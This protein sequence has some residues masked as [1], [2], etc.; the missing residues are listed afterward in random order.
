MTQKNRPPADEEK[1]ALDRQQPGKRTYK[2]PEFRLEKVFETM[3]LACGKLQGTVALC[4]HRRR[5]S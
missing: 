5:S 1:N 2:K 3:A 4:K